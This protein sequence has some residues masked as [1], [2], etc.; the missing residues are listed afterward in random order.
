MKI[1]YIYSHLNGLEF[2]LVHKRELWKEIEES[3][4]SI[5]ADKYKKVSK[6]KASNGKVIFD[7]KGINS[8]FKDYLLPKGWK[9]HKKCYYFT[10]DEELARET[11]SYSQEEQKSEIESRGRIAFQGYNQTDFLKDNIAVEVQFGKYSF[12]AYDLFVKHM[13]FYISNDIDVG[14][15]ILPTKALQTKMDVG[16]ACYE[17]EVYNVYRAGRNT[18]AVPL[19]VIGIEPDTDEFDYVGEDPNS[20]WEQ[21]HSEL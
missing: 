1:R 18:P 15:E 11:L 17:K 10:P 19:V 3:I 8:A 13:A 7:Q 6:A 9:D 12:V 5:D 21:N 4:K 20:F 14:I 16:V 2:L